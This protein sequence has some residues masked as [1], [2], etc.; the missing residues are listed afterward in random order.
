MARIKTEEVPITVLVPVGGRII[1]IYGEDANGMPVL[2]E[3]K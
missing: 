1:K 2:L 3:I